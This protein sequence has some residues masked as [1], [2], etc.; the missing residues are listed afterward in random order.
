[1]LLKENTITPFTYRNSIGIAI[2]QGAFELAEEWVEMHKKYLVEEH[3]ESNYAYCKAW[4]A[5]EQG[6]YRG[7]RKYLQQI[8]FED[9]LLALNSKTLFFQH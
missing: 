6:H 1:M 9:E 5:F 2:K 8:E 4:I 7:V 3:L